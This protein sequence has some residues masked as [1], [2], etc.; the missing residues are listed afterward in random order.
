[1]ITA[2]KFPLEGLGF[3]NGAVV[4]KEIP[5]SQA[6]SAEQLR[7]SMA[8]AMALNPK[9]RV[10][11][12]TDGSLLDS[13][14]MKVI[15]EMANAQDFQIWCEIVDESGKVGIVIEDGAVAAVN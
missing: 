2:A 8:M 12:I 1:M 5:L 14:S 9:V 10:I 13:S 4:Y 11:R 15:D 7:V 6:S 3:G